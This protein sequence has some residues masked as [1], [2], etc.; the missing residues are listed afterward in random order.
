[1][2]SSLIAYQFIELSLIRLMPG[3][4]SNISHLFNGDEETVLSPVGDE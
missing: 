4:E 2:I 3:D 1:M